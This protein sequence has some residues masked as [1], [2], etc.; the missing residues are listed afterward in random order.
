MD[1]PPVP[2][3]ISRCPNNSNSRN[4]SNCMDWGKVLVTSKVSSLEHELRNHT[5][6]GRS[7]VSLRQSTHFL[8]TAIR[9]HFVRYTIHG[10]SSSFWEQRHRTIYY[11]HQYPPQN[12]TIAPNTWRQCCGGWRG[13]ITRRFVR[14]VDCLQ[15]HQSRR[16]TLLQWSMREIEI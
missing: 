5:V 4:S 1:F 13:E 9:I 2:L 8:D 3:S 10:S 7:C 12:E 14:G 15:R 16:W 11:H 6:K